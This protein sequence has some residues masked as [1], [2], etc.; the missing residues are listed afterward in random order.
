MQ[1]KDMFLIGG[2]L[3]LGVVSALFF[4]FT[5]EAGG[6]AI[7][8]IDGA[9][10]EEYP[11]DEDGVYTIET[12]EGYNVLTIKD[13]IVDMTEADCPDHIC[14]EHIAIGYTGE[15]IVCLPHKLV[16]EVVDGEER[17]MDLVVG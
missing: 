16:V 5:K 4:Q 6:T 12:A 3:L 13:G 7:V 10:V 14:V 9:V 15:T 17:E 2:I 11:L 1:K 8:T